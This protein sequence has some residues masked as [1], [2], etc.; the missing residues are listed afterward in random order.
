MLQLVSPHGCSTQTP[1]T[2]A[3]PCRLHSR[4]PPMAAGDRLV[5]GQ[6]A[7]PVAGVRAAA[8]CRRHLPGPVAAAAGPARALPSPAPGWAAQNRREEQ[9]SSDRHA[10]AGGGE[11]QVPALASAAAACARMQLWPHLN[12][13]L[14]IPEP[15]ERGWRDERLGETKGPP[16]PVRWRAGLASH[17]C[18][19]QRGARSAAA[20]SMPP[21]RAA[22][23]LGPPPCGARPRFLPAS[24]KSREHVGPA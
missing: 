24:F 13:R 1:C 2:L 8:R 16:R 7:C 18:R 17:G 9:G 6:V 19:L 3:R 11:R 23:G 4:R 5:G 14:I 12:T 22:G 10:G 21:S 20:L 15:S